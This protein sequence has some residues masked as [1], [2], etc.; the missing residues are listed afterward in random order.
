MNPNDETVALAAALWAARRANAAGIALIKDFEGLRLK[1]YR[2]QAG[3]WTVGYGHTR[4]A[5]PDMKI[6]PQEAEELLDDDLRMVERAVSKLV[7]VKLNDNQFSALVCFAFNVGAGNFERSTLLKLLNRGWYE[8]VPAQLSRWNR[9][10]GEA[11][12]G[13][14][15]RRRA[16]A[17]LWNSTLSGQELTERQGILRG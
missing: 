3:L 10:A 11:M 12:G 5:R 9:V 4:T 1:S 17:K 16:E 6:T 7:T 2:C 13:L 8:Q 14:S 15:R